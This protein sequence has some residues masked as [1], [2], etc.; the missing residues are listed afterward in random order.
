[1]PNR[2]ARHRI[3]IVSGAVGLVVGAL[4][5]GGIWGVS[6]AVQ[7][8]SISAAVVPK[9][10]T[11]TEPDAAPS[12]SRTPVLGA[13]GGEAPDDSG[14]DGGS[15]KGNSSRKGSS[16]AG[17]TGGTATAAPAAACAS[18]TVRVS[19]AAALT[20][21]LRAA[22]AGAVIALANGTYS[23]NFEGTAQGTAT[24][25]IALCGGSGAV[26]DGGDPTDGYVVHLDGGAYWTLS[27][28][29]VQNGQK[30]VMLDD[31]QHSVVQGLTVRKIG[32]EA[33]HVR[34]NSSDNTLRGNH[35]SETGLR[36]PKFGEGIYIG[37]SKNNW[38]DVSD[39]KPDRSDRNVVTANT[40]TGTGAE[41]VDIKEGTTGGVLSD[42]SFDGSGMQGQNHADSWV[43]VKG[44]G[45]SV[46]GN[47]GVHST[48][49]GFQTHE[50]LDGWG[51][52]N[53]F[54]G[55]T[56]DLGNSDGVAFAFRPVLGNTVSCD[57]D[58]VGSNEFSTTKCTS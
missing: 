56:V 16:T 31:T 36:K 8:P 1:M 20:A 55:N 48:L 34:A 50:L 13:L 25:P 49:D 53:T 42:N 15:S 57:N 3:Q 10:S 23:G 26:L 58:V 7:G 33:V 4:V 38:C 54:S 30:G 24:K 35:V 27:G 11:S 52:D 28:F 44:N 41:N 40:I 5:V 51:T 29:T 18:P 46:T 21:A 17:G 2:F 45:W 6:A 47:R 12:A 14:K 9:P 19:T 22:K 39:C 43:D 32:D 37:S